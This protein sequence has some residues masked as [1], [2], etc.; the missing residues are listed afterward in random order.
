MS[1]QALLEKQ[2]GRIDRATEELLAARHARSR[3]DDAPTCT[4][5]SEASL[6]LNPRGTLRLATVSRL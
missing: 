2:R 6:R 5:S 1:E 4:P 3:K